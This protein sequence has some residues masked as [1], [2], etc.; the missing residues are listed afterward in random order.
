MAHFLYRHK[1]WVRQG[2]KEDG[3][4]FEATRTFKAAGG[5]AASSFWE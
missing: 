3:G 1:R 2:V 5:L 4:V